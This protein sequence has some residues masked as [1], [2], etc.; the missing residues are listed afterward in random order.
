[1]RPRAILLIVTLPTLGV[2]SAVPAEVA[3]DQRTQLATAQRLSR[4]AAVRS[5][6]L[7][8]LAAGEQNKAAQAN[9]R[10]AAVAARIDQ[11][12]AD[13]VASQTRIAIVGRL[14]EAQR[15]RLAVQ[16]QPVARLLA[17]LQSLALRPAVIN[18]VQPGSI[19]DLVHVRAVLAST[20]P[21][22]RGRTQRV[23]ARLERFRT[24]QA[25]VRAAGQALAV[26]R[27]QLETQR[28][29][30]NRLE[31]AHR[32]RA[33][34][35]G[36]NALFESDRA[37]ALGENARDLVDVMDQASLSATT[38]QHL[39]A[40]PGPLP[41]PPRPGMFA[42]SELRPWSSDT[43]PYRLPVAG[44][45]I[46]GFGELS[47]TGVRSRGLTLLSAG[48]APLVAP[49]AGR[50]AY[51]APFRGYGSI[52][53]LDHGGGWTS[54]VAGLGDV[55]VRVGEHIAQGAPIGRTAKGPTARITVE[56]RRRDRT[57]DMTPLLG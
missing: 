1:M 22:I 47:D 45:I 27:A 3:A 29:A 26:G 6:V 7:E 15:A 53:I 55:A 14:L 25:Q 39:A 37:I 41:R 10:E 46:T 8:R 42:P 23:R 17:A 54:L 56:L 16:Q 38:R 19:D 20:L 13:I 18:V 40:L 33:R 35:L 50:V 31:L 57:I 12:E 9:A 24:R 49:A 2:G 11:A 32:L 34:M 48:A 28:L 21:A 4:A 44:A 43:A 5:S 51:A 30:L 52:V 36:R